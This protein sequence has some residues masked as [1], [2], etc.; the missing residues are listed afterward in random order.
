MMMAALLAGCGGGGGGSAWTGPTIPS[1]EAP[2]SGAPAAAE[3]VGSL[4]GSLA[5]EGG[6]GLIQSD[7]PGSLANTSFTLTIANNA[8]DFT[9]DASAHFKIDDIPVGVSQA[10]SIFNETYFKDGTANV[11][12]GQTTSVGAVSIPAVSLAAPSGS[13][14]FSITAFGYTGYNS[15]SEYVTAYVY[16][17]RWDNLRAPSYG[18]Y[19]WL[20]GT[21]TSGYATFSS[22]P[23]PAS[24]IYKYKCSITFL[25]KYYDSE[26]GTY[27]DGK[28]LVVKRFA[29]IY[30][31]DTGKWLSGST[32]LHS[33][34]IKSKSYY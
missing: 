30:P 29:N 3:A 23:V 34:E 33:Y 13:C 2:P 9:T 16:K 24:Q 27:S 20:S 28:Q 15:F 8:Y 5:P 26:S 1:V 7:A 10:Y 6:S 22:I 18:Q 25:V 21:D 31:T 12:T 14:K 19:E 32:W 4:E 11:T 17:L